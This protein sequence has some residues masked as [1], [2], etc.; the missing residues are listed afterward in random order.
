MSTSFDA[1]DR[2][3]AA[4]ELLR[5]ALAR[6]GAVARLTVRGAS[7]APALGDGESVE[8]VAAPTCATLRTGEVVVALA[9]NGALVC[10]RVLARGRGG[11]L[12]I[13]GDADRTIERVESSALI[14]VVA[15]RRSLGSELRARGRW[16]AFRSRRAVRRIAQ[17]LRARLPS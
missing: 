16:L 13:A 17:G 11:A 8:L 5:R 14:G 2:C 15:R 7:M 12:W 10:H 4:I 1:G 9:T 6:E 3:A